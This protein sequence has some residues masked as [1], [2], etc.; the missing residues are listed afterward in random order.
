MRLGPIY[1]M[2]ICFLS[3]SSYPTLTGRN[4]GYAGGAEVQQVHLARELVAHG[5]ETCFVTYRHGQNDIENVGAIEM[6]KTY[7]RE[8]ASKMNAL[9]KYRSI[10][11]SLKKA[12]ADI[13]FHSAGS[14]G[15]L[16]LFCC[17]NR[18]KFVYRISS[19]AVALSKPIPKEYNFF[20]RTLEMLEIKRANVVVAQTNFQKSILRE[21]FEVESVLIKN[22]LPIPKA[23]C[24]KP[25]PPIVLWVGSISNVKNAHLFIELAKSIPNA[26]FEMVGGKTKN[27]QLYEKIKE[28]AKMLSNFKFYGFVPYHKVNEF[29]E[30]ASIL[31]NTSSVEGFPNTFLQ[32]WAHYTPVISLNVDPDGI[33]NKNR[34]GFCSKTFKQLV[35][36]V[37]RLLKDE[38]LRKKMGENGRKYVEKEHDIQEITKKYIKAFEEILHR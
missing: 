16:P 26:K 12:N 29:F 11:S 23:N 5:Y 25:N 17:A 37:N 8:N 35:S 13:Y 32:A 38:A 18:K 7:D 27:W 10:W 3:L 19:D 14:T 28:A 31:V 22:G 33:I 2:K 34:L 1:S 15:V 6:I 24:E 20:D 21:R 36:D 9:L 30:K 4:L